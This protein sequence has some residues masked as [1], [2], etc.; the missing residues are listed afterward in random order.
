[1]DGP[2][3]HLVP[4]FHAEP[5][6]ARRLRRLLRR[7]PAHECRY[8]AITVSVAAAC[9]VL[10]ASRQGRADEPE[11]RFQGVYAAVAAG[12]HLSS[13][14]GGRKAPGF[15]VEARVGISEGAPFATYLSYSIESSYP[16]SL[17]PP[18]C[19]CLVGPYQVSHLAWIVQHHLLVRPNLAV[20]GRIGLGVALSGDFSKR[21]DFRPNGPILAGP[22]ESVAVG[23]ELPLNRDLFLAPELVFRNADVPANFGHPGNNNVQ[24]V[25]VQIALVYY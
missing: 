17:S 12:G 11:L 8:A 6:K 1:M 2:G 3:R 4:R 16:K 14:I 20:Y 10:L 22:A 24:S 7:L 15:S 13:A 19:F 9:V 23:T 18:S 25:A 21:G 5:V